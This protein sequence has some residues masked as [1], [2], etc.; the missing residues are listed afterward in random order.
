MSRQGFTLSLTSKKQQKE[1][2]TDDIVGRGQS[3]FFSFP[4]CQ[5]SPLLITSF[6]L[7]PSLFFFFFFLIESLLDYDDYFSLLISL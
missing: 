5:I 4:P 6:L 7:L 3:L 1:E 2:E